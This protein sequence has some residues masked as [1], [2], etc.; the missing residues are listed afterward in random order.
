MAWHRGPAQWWSGQA[1]AVKPA[2][3]KRT[4]GCEEGGL[5]G[6]REAKAELQGWGHTARAN[7]WVT[8]RVD[9]EASAGPAPTQLKAVCRPPAAFSSWRPKGDAVAA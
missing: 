4:E 8:E 9:R 2:T 5:L 6:V 3:A 1:K 7:P